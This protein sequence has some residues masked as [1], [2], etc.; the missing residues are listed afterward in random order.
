VWDSGGLGRH[1]KLTLGVRRSF[2]SL[3]IVPTTLLLFAHVSRQEE[4]GAVQPVSD[5][6]F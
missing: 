4:T 6:V 2:E 5:L 3:E 1:V